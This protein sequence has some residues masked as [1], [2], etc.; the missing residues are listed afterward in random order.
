VKGLMVRAVGM[1]PADERVDVEQVFH[2]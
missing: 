2:G 1:V